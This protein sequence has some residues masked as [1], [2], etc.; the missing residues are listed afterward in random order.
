MIVDTDPEAVESKIE[1]EPVAATP[2]PVHQVTTVSKYLALALFIILPFLGGYIGYRLAPEKVVEVPMKAPVSNSQGMKEKIAQ[3]VEAEKEKAEAQTE[4]FRMQAEKME[5]DLAMATS[6]YVQ[7]LYKDVPCSVTLPTHVYTNGTKFGNFTMT[8]H[9]QSCMYDSVFNSFNFTGE[10]TLRGEIS[11]DHSNEAAL[12]MR[13]DPE[14]LSKLPGAAMGIPEITEAMAQNLDAKDQ[15]L[16]PFFDDVAE[17]AEKKYSI[18]VTISDMNI[19]NSAKG[20]GIWATLTGEPK[21]ISV[22]GSSTQQ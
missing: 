16:K 19:S 18:E 20:A 13:I 10:V 14:Y 8:R 21:I 4:V 2:H 3:F 1:T 5:G 22:T 9:I 7:S 6:T 11:Q 12:F 15:A 17:H